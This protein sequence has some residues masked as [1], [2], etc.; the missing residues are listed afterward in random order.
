[1]F[2]LISA[3]V[4]YKI[5]VSKIHRQF[6]YTNLQTIFITK[7]NR[8]EKLPCLE[9]K[10]FTD[11]EN[12]I[13]FNEVQKIHK[14]LQVD[15]NIINTQCYLSNYQYNTCNTWEVRLT[16]GPFSFPPVL[17]AQNSTFYFLSPF[18]FFLFYR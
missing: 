5:F 11:Y 3:K 2:D 15:S 12:Q 14:K 4:H 6:S 16:R 7:S 1:M 18:I 13:I 17:V 9:L 8:P 10:N